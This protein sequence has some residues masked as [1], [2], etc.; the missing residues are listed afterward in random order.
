M[1]GADIN[2]ADAWKLTAGNPEVIVAI[3]DEGVK[4]THPDLAA[5]MWINPNPS[6]EYGKQ[7][8]HGW[9][10]VTDGPISWGQKGDSGHGTHVAGTVAAVNN[11][12]IGVCGVAGGTGKGDGV[13][14]MSCHL[15]G[16]P[17]G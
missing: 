2:V 9:N 7:D 14:L 6:P 11:N 3:V 10:F 13:R 4:Y 16:R 17:D 1:A 15:L 12:G 8:I 5:N